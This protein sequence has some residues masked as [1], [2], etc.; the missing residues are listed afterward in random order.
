MNTARVNA[1]AK[2]NLTLDIVGEEDGF[3]MLDSLVVSV[4]LSDR[5]V[6]RK[7]ADG[8]SSVAMHGMGS[9]SIPPEKNNALFAAERFSKAFKTTGADLTIYKNIPMGAGMGGS[10]ADAAGVLL[11]MAKLYGVKNR[12]A[13][14]A[15]A[16]ELGSDVKFQLSGG[17]ARM[18]GRG[19]DLA[20]FGEVPAMW[21]F[22]VCPAEGVGSG[23]CYAEFDRQGKTFPPRTG[24]A[25]EGLGSGNLDWGARLFGNHLTE[26]AIAI[27]PEIGEILKTLRAFSP[28][29]AA[30][31]GSGSAVFAAFPT[32]E[33][34]QWA[35]SRYRGR[36]RAYVLRAIDPKRIK[37][38]RNPYVLGEDEGQERR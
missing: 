27:D 6:A 2:L 18:R 23:A 17:F 12:D 30:M 20:F 3:H 21:F 8:H 10:S 4:D 24:R 16:E 33:L 1:Y 34:A 5:I 14:A 37:S 35:K 7:R 31:T 26:A 19:E 29:G 36:H 32:L 38:W 22:A 13:L 11:A 25:I 28:I 15:L 9:E